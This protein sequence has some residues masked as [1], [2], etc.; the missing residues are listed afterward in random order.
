MLIWLLFTVFCLQ[1]AANTGWGAN[2]QKGRWDHDKFD[3]QPRSERKHDKNTQTRH[4]ES[5]VQARRSHDTDA[6]HTSKGKEM[7]NDGRDEKRSRRHADEELET[8]DDRRQDK[9]P[10]RSAGADPFKPTSKDYDRR[11]ESRARRY[12]DEHYAH[13]L[14]EGDDRRKDKR[15]GWDNDDFEPRGKEGY[16][17]TEQKQSRRHESESYSRKNGDRRGENRSTRDG[18]L[19]SSRHRGRDDRRRESDL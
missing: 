9:R 6:R 10:R 15:S 11:E 4:P 3:G 8:R 1:R 16:D 2:D 18:D 19:S 17:R 12:D 14:R 7:L 13:K 5:T